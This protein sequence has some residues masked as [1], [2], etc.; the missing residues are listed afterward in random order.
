MLG[1]NVAFY[2]FRGAPSLLRTLQRCGERVIILSVGLEEE[3]EILCLAYKQSLIW[4]QLKHTWI[5]YEHQ[6]EDFF[7]A[8]NTCDNDTM[9]SAL[10]G[11]FLIQYQFSTNDSNKVIVSGQTYTEYYDDYHQRLSHFATQYNTSLDWNPYSNALHDSVWATAIALNI[12]RQTLEVNNG[13]AEKIE[14]LDT[15]FTGALGDVNFDNNAEFEVTINIFLIRN[16][17][18]ELHTVL[19]NVMKPP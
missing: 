16:G 2:P 1:G 13:T 6:V 4:P 9:R 11:V 10:E 19:N 15:A 5:V 14:I 17:T 12:S 8:T 3:A 18:A 7:H